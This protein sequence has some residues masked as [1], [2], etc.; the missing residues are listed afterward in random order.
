MFPRLRLLR[1]VPRRYLSVSLPRRASPFSPPPA[2]DPATLE[3]VKNSEVYQ[4]L[5]KN[6]EAL[7]AVA[8]FAEIM[9]ANGIDMSSGKPPSM[10]QMSKMLMKSEVRQ[11]ATDLSEALKKAG[12]DLTNKDVM[13][14]V[15][16]F[17]KLGGTGQS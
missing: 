7:E 2:I 4:K 17:A 12:I 3:A 5:A 13:Q 6:K 14:Q 10:L 16:A 8:K 11:V 1:H 9:Q 15:S